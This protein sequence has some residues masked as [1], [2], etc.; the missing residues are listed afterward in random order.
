MLP[1]APLTTPSS[2]AVVATSDAMVDE[3]TERAAA[4][5]NTSIVTEWS[6]PFD[7][8][9]LWKAADEDVLRE[10]DGGDEEMQEDGSGGFIP[11]EDQAGMTVDDSNKYAGLAF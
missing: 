7:L 11:D 6:K 8:D 10:G 9:G 3:A 5:A 2:A 1:P 4:F